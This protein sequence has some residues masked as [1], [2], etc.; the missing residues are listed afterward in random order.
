VKSGVYKIENPKGRI[1]VGSSFDVEKRI[2]NYKKGWAG[3]GQPKLYNSFMKYGAVNH[4][5]I[6]LEFCEKS[7]TRNRE[8]YWQEQLQVISDGGLNCVLVEA[9]GIPKQHTEQ[10]K[11]K[12]SNTLTGRLKGPHT[13]ERIANISKARKKA[14]PGKQPLLEIGLT[15]GGMGEMAQV[16]CVSFPT[17]KRQ[18]QEYSIHIELKEYWGNKKK[19]RI[20]QLIEK[21]STH[22]INTE[23]LSELISKEELIGIQV[24]RKIIK[25]YGKQAEIYQ[26]MN[27]NKLNNK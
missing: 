11:A 4:T 8:R 22:A 24:L 13:L 7:E 5:Y 9:R 18:L 6:I 20:M 16:L 27:S 21:Y 25:Q 10:T 19:E 3:K 12:I 15:V 2:I 23:H 1:Y 14:W 17:L 26:R